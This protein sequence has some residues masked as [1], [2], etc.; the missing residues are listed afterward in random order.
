MGELYVVKDMAAEHIEAVGAMLIAM[1]AEEP[2]NYSI[3]VEEV[4]SYSSGEKFTLGMR[5]AL[6][7][8]KFGRFVVL[9]GSDNCVGFATTRV[10]P[11]EEGLRIGNMYVKPELRSEGLGARLLGACEARAA[12]DG[13]KQT[14]LVVGSK[15]TGARKFYIRHGYGR[16]DPPVLEAWELHP[17]LYGEMLVKNLK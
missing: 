1:V 6:A 2:K 7:E 9:D 12:S 10:K 16:A 13:H 3:S 14:T 17:G 8:N 4:T 11:D 15:N 5:E